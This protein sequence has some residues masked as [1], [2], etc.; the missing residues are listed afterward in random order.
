MS[1]LVRR[2]SEAFHAVWKAYSIEC[3]PDGLYSEVFRAEH[4]NSAPFGEKLEKLMLVFF[5][6]TLIWKLRVG[7]E[8][9]SRRL[10]PGR[11]VC[12]LTSLLRRLRRLSSLLSSTPSTQ[13]RPLDH[14]NTVLL[15]P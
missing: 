11:H 10:R 15:R 8:A 14:I 3:V 7:V 6:V 13:R 2:R 4:R 1:A 5:K 12:A 9:R